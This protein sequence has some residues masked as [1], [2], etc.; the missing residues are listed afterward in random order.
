[1]TISTS[2]RLLGVMALLAGFGVGSVV[3]STASG[4]HTASTYIPLTWASDPDYYF[5]D[6]DSPLSGPTPESSLHAGNDP[7]NANSGTWLDINWGGVYD[8]SVVWTGSGCTTGYGTR[9]WVLTHSISNL[10]TESTCGTST[11]ITRSS[12]RF[13]DTRSNW[14]VGSSSSVPSGQYDLRSVAVHEFG[15]AGGFSGHW[16]GVGE[17][18]TGSDRETMCSGLPSGTS[19]KRSIEAHE[20]HTFDSAY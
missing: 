1:M 14:Y 6:L 19:Y 12:I 10:A 8:S 11:T 16:D 5:G 17:D 7:W 15:H 4:A 3:G 20:N 2:N 18:C 13:D 9:L